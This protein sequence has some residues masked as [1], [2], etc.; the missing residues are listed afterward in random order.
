[1]R[2]CN[3]LIGL[4]NNCDQEIEEQDSTQDDVAEPE[5]PQ[6]IDDNRA[7][8]NTEG[9]VVFRILV[10]LDIIKPSFIRWRLKITDG[11]SKC[12]NEHL[13]ELVDATI[14]LFIEL[15]HEYTVLNGEE[16]NPE[17]EERHEWSHVKNREADH[18]YEETVVCKDF[19]KE[20]Q[21]HEHLENQKED[22]QNLEHV[23]RSI[24]REE[25]LAE[26]Q[27]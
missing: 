18:L 1:M 3:S 16:D 22:E 19:H 27:N 6:E 5:A 26:H 10:G 4:R 25:E 13:D 8:S 2:S 9:V 12:K 21:F 20:Q 23:F 7:L 24:S 17:S 11:V 15:Q 14:L